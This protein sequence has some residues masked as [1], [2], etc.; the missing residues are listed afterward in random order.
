[1]VEKYIKSVQ[2]NIASSPSVTDLSEQELKELRG[3]TD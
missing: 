3:E 2:P 1:L